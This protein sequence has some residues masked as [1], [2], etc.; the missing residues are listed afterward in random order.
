MARS[1]ETQ[2]DMH[3]VHDKA[4]D[5]VEGRLAELIA[6]GEVLLNGYRLSGHDRAIIVKAL[7]DRARWMASDITSGER[8]RRS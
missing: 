1:K 4:G 5:T 8:R 6:E 7:L 2:A 3:G